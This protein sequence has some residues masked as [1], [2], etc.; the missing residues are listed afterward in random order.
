MH[1]GRGRSVSCAG[2]ED[3]ESEDEQLNEVR[4]AILRLKDDYRE[5]LVLMGHS[6]SEIAELTGMKQ[7]AVLTRLHRAR[8]K[9]KEVVEQGAEASVG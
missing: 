1:G 7:G 2:D 8:H 4:E 5:L 6:T 9:L 3:A